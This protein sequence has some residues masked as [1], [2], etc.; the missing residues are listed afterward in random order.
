MPGWQESTMG[1]RR[2]E[3]LPQNAHD[4]LKRIEE[5][6]GVEV[7]MISTGAERNENIVL[8]HPFD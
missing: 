5:I 8:R 2:W 3:D 4:Y 6:A 1:T 7:N